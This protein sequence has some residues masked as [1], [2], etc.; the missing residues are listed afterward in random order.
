MHLRL[1]PSCDFFSTHLYGRLNAINRIKAIKTN[2]F[3][4]TVVTMQQT[5]KMIL[6]LF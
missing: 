6:S 5:L 2:V 4:T 1:N 3:V